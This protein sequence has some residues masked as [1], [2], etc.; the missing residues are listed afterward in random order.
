MSKE[1]GS[2]QK[3]AAGRAKTNMLQQPGYAKHVPMPAR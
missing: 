3:R 1:K 2:G